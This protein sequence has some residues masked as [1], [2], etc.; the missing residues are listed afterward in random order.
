ME[1]HE[2]VAAHEETVRPLMTE[3]ALAWWGLNTTGEEEH[4]ERSREIREQVGKIYANADDYGRLKAW[5]EAG[6]AG[7]RIGDATLARQIRLLHL[8]YAGSQQDEETI[9]REAELGT[10]LSQ[11]FTNFRPEVGGE[12]ISQ[13]DLLKILTDGTD[14][15]ARRE[16][17][18]A[19]HAVGREARADILDL[20]ALRN[21]TATKLGYRDYYQMSLTLSEIDEDDLFATLD[22]LEELCAEPFASAKAVL[23]EELAERL[24]VAR[25][26]LM[27]WHYADPFFQSAPPSGG[28][29]LDGVFADADIADLTVRTYDGLGLQ[30]RS[31]L[32]G[33]DLYPRDGKCEHAF[34]INI[35]REGD[36]RVLCNIAPSER[37]MT[38]MLHEFGHAV[39][40]RFISPDLPFFLRR[41]AHA[42][43]TEAVAILMQRFTQDAAWL[44]TVGGVG[45]E[46]AAELAEGILARARLEKLIFVKWC[47]V[48]CHFERALYGDPDAD[49]NR[50][51]WDLRERFQLVK[52]P[53]GRDEP[54]WAAKIHLAVAPVY[55]QNYL[56]GELMAS[57]LEAHLREQSST[58]EMVNSRAVGRTL[59]DRLFRPGRLRPWNE[60]LERVTGEALNPEHF[61][62]QYGV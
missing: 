54:D 34:C 43:S 37:W 60:A 6:E 13:N 21:E 15:G 14:S 25:D 31:M 8:D 4:A 55:Y 7:E 51:W 50:L 3:G 48:M 32:E 40:D 28:V 17:W 62:T 41:P 10:K 9:R 24:G 18:E 52:R 56:L 5:D 35:D 26:D 27:P 22:R 1:P 30:I 58:G 57:Q 39:Y 59:V 33:S 11:L 61:L 2:F 20:V 53:G 29:D 42:L 19:S 44:A 46:R 23:D 12:A 36:V 49:R 16:A 47:L 45:V 38:T